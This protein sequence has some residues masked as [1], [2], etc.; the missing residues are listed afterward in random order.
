M[1]ASDLQ[2]KEIEHKFIVDDQFDLRRF[3]HA[4]DRLHPTRTNSVRVQDRYYL[5]DG[6]QKRRFVIRHRYDI[7]LQHLTLKAIEADTE[8]RAEINLDL[9]HQAGDQHEAVDAFLDHLG[10]RWSG[11]IHKDLDVWHFPDIEVVHYHAS[12]TARSV[13]CVEFEATRKPSLAGAPSFTFG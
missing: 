4:L 13:R 7:E 2:F 1:T 9:G 12:T 10:V 8:T 6:G 3:R 5:T 11:T